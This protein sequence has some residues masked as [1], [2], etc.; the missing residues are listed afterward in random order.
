MEDSREI[1][2]INKNGKVRFISEHLTKDAQYMRQMELTIEDVS[3][4]KKHFEA[5][6][7]KVQEDVITGLNEE[8]EFSIMLEEENKANKKKK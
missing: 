8:D 2:C 6:K 1:R 3:V 5:L 4:S 7:E